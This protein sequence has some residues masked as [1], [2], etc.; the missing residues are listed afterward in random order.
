MRI[1]VLAAAVLMASSSSGFAQDTS[2]GEARFKSLCNPCHDVGPAPKPKLGPHLNGINGRKAG[3]V[4][5]SNYSEANKN[6]GI[7]WNAETF[8]EYIK[9]P[10]Q[11]MPGTRMA[12][13]GVRDEKDI[14]NL[15]AFLSS[16]SEDGNRK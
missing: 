9:N 3:T 6:S 8:A 14:A 16:F 1:W 7:T 5:K 2:A 10:M 11:R 13:A 12:F 15:W 4:E